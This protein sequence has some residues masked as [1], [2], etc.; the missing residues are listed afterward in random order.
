MLLTDLLPWLTSQS[1]RAVS[2]FWLEWGQQPRGVPTELPQLHFLEGCM[3]ALLG[4]NTN[5]RATGQFLAKLALIVRPF[6][7]SVCR[8]KYMF[9]I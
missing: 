8:K 3:A 5:I 1:L 9:F 6:L 4:G 7:V 2:G